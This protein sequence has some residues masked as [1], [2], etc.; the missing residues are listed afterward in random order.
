M[1]KSGVSRGSTASPTAPQG[2]DEA[3]AFVEPMLATLPKDKLARINVDIPRAV[4]TALGA[5][6]RLAALRDQAAKLPNFDI[7][8]IDRIGTY[9]L[10]AWYTHVLAMPKAT[11]D[12]LGDLMKEA[13]T[14]REDMLL[15]A[16]LLARKGHLDSAMVQAIRADQ[17]N[18]DTVNDLVA[19][20]TLFSAAWVRIEHKTTVE[21]RDVERASALGSEL[22]VALGV[23]AQPSLEAPATTPA[24]RRVRA[25]T[26]FVRAYDQC[27]RAAT[28]LRWN[29]GDADQF[30]PSLIPGRG[31]RKGKTARRPDVADP[32]ESALAGAS[33]GPA[34]GN[35][36]SRK[37]KATSRKTKRK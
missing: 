11:P 35:E 20:A 10:A 27:R 29:E 1:K 16:E 21:W 15:A 17:G 37:A 25:F 13:K 26:L 36:T 3:L 8:N 12:A 23:R 34:E 24:D 5:A 28:Y 14:L 33:E 6:R 2:A 18:M 32:P 7:A 9:A 4:T 31:G 22:L 19:L 30:V